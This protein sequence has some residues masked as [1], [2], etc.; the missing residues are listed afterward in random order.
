MTRSLDRTR[1]FGY[2]YGSSIGAVYSQDG[3]DFNG[4]GEL[5]SPAPPEKIVVETDD[6]DSAQQ[7]LKT[8]LRNPLSKA[9][10]FKTAEGNNQPWD[11]VKDA[12]VKLGIVKFK[13]QGVETWKLPEEV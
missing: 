1:E 11:S 3:L 4:A 9:A 2:V 7:F 10:V 5:I 13:Y 6:L 8:V 12:A